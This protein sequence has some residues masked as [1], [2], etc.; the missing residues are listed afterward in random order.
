[1]YEMEESEIVFKD[2]ESPP[3]PPSPVPRSPPASPAADIQYEDVLDMVHK[4]N[5][6]LGLLDRDNVEIRTICNQLLRENQARSGPDRGFR[7]R[8]SHHRCRRCLPWLKG[9]DTRCD[10]LLVGQTNRR[11]LLEIFEIFLFHSRT[12]DTNNEYPLGNK[13]A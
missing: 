9:W 13:R 1:M 3:D 8:R 2:T 5:N 10:R 11:D 7:S 6:E 4:I 12:L